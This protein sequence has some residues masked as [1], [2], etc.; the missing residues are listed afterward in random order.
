MNPLNKNGNTTNTNFYTFVNNLA[1]PKNFVEQLLQ[2]SPQAKS[3]L[4]RP[5]TNPRDLAYQLAK[6]R[7]IPEE[8]LTQVARMFGVK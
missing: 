4:S 2:N 6:S 8:Q 1:S 5:N 3:L 7:N